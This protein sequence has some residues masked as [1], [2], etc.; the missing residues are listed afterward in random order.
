MVIATAI[1]VAS[2]SCIS[3]HFK[4][5]ERSFMKE[6]HQRQAFKKLAGKN[7]ALRKF[8]ISV[9]LMTSVDRAGIVSKKYV[10][11]SILCLY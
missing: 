1:S 7:I 5:H 8:H 11:V 6:I 10:G 2:N 4:F 9:H 3:Y